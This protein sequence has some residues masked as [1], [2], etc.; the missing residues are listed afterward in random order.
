MKMDQNRRFQMKRWLTLGIFTILILGASSALSEVIPLR[1]DVQDDEPRIEITKHDANLLQLDVRIGSL[2]LYQ[3]MLDGK[4]WDRVQIPGGSYDNELGVPEVPSFSRMIAIPANAG[5]QV[6]FE[7]LEVSTF[8]D[9]DLMPMQEDEPEV[10]QQNKSP[11][12]FASSAYETDSFGPE[13]QA[14]NGDPALMYGIRLVP[15]KMKPVRY[16]PVS[17]ELR[18]AHHF[19]VTIHFQGIDTRNQQMR[20]IRPMSKYRYNML[21]GVIPNLDLLDIDVTE[22]GKYLIICEEDATLINILAPLIDWKKRMGHEVVLETFSPGS[23][24]TTIKNIIQN[25]YNN[26]DVPPEWVLLFGDESGN[27]TLPAWY[28]VAGYYTC[29]ID[30][31]YSLLEGND[32]LAD[33]SIARY[34]ADDD[35]QAAMMVNKTLLYEKT[36]F[37]A[38]TNWYREGVLVAGSSASGMSSIQC[39]RWIKDRMVQRNYA[40]IDTFWYTGCPGTVVSTLTNG[41]NEG[42]LYVNYRGWV[43]MQGFGNDD[44]QNLTNARMLPFVAIPT[45]G[46][47]GWSGTSNMECFMNV[48]SP[49][50][51]TGAVACFG[52]AT[53]GTHTRFNNAVDVGTFSAIFDEDCPLPGPALDRGKIELYNTFWEYDMSYVEEFSH[54][55]AMGGDP[56]LI[57]FTQGIQ[58]LNCNIPATMSWGENSISLTVNEP[59][60][61]PVEDAVVCLYKDGDMQEVG[62]TDVNGLVTLPL[63]PST[64]GNVKVTITKQNYV[65]IV[66][67]L[68]VIQEAVVVG[69]YSNTIDDDNNGTSSGDNDGIANPGETVELPLVF[70]NYGNSTT[71]TNVSVTATVDD[72]Y[73]T[74]NDASET[75]PNMTPGSTANSTDDFDLVI[76]PACPDGH[77]IILNLTT[78]SD[79]DSWDGTMAVDVVS[80]DMLLNSYT[81]GSDTL[82]SP[83]ETS[84]LVLNVRN[85]GSKAASSLTA[86]L[87]TSSPYVTVNDANA[88]FG[89]VGIG[90]TASCSG[91][92]FNVTC[93][94]DAPP[95]YPAEFD[96]TYASSGG[97]TQTETITVALGSRSTVDA[98]GPDEYGYWC[99]D[100]TDVEYSPSPEYNWV[101]I[102]SFGTQLPIYDN[103]ENQDMSVLVNLPFTFQYYGEQ[104]NQITVCSNGWISSTPNVAYSNAANH[105]IPSCMGPNGLIAPFWDDLYSYSG[106]VVYTWYD[107]ANHRFVIQWD[108]FRKIGSGSERYTFECIL[109]DEAYYPTPTNDSEIVFQY[110]EVYATYGDPADIPYF[111]TGIERPDHLDGIEVA[112]WN[113][114]HDPATAPVQNNRAYKFTTNFGYTPPGAPNITVDLTYNSGSPVPVGGGNLYFDTYVLNAGTSPVD[115]DA[116]IDIEYEGGPPTTVIERNLVNYMPGWTIDRP[117]MYFPVPAAYAAGNYDL[118]GRVGNHPS[119]IWNESGFPFVKSGANAGGDFVPFV[120][121]GVP[122]YF[123]VITTD[124]GI[125][126]LP[127]EYEIVGTYPNPFNPTTTISYALPEAG[128]VNLQVYDVTGRQV[129]TLVDGFRNAGIHNV[130]F[131]A[132]GLASGIYIYRLTAGSFNTIGKLVLMK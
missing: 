110:Q 49:T 70:K 20:P 2:E 23:S 88:S 33:V 61:G 127:Q 29:Y 1:A 16:N 42:A 59:G 79:Q 119:N 6:E 55:N 109:Y 122:D 25:A 91:N 87:A 52:T 4:M 27:Y 121:N 93:T 41:I 50:A 81:L 101:E 26:W 100:N 117:N 17:K 78:T 112:Y 129:A 15:V 71:A 35:Y 113:T 95:G 86:S 115:F 85:I 83:G 84:N 44:I 103:G 40:D 72:D 73:A 132:H 53:T 104:T 116:W 28:Y 46:T 51:P 32:V 5:A 63:N 92:P 98:Q 96:I 3:S 56:G 31:P 125:I 62:A 97:A 130:Q 36:P 124:G 47:G 75:F 65:P 102:A 111:T 48:G 94:E 14:V 123:A 30:H 13:V 108:Y 34:P 106:G 11:V 43:G 10:I 24:N 118:I 120:P 8:S 7:P 37:L 90:S 54:W 82:L 105:P 60:V 107:T 74:L 76:D 80:Y 131:D 22:M 67:S 38:Q 89:T 99:Y 18:V 45:C 12:R 128:K 58:Y 69:Y 39:N 9:V 19:Q 68:D 66:D 21:K 77:T 126:E 114:Y 57:M 64:S